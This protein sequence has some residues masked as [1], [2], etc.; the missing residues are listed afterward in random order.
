MSC[1]ILFAALILLFTAGCLGGGEDQT[2]STTTS[3]EPAKTPPTLP[4][5]TIQQ[6]AY[7]S[8]NN[9]SWAKNKMWDDGATEYAVYNS[10]RIVDGQPVNYQT[11]TLTEAAYFDG[12]Y[13]VKNFNNTPGSTPIL[14][15]TTI[16]DYN[17]V[18]YPTSIMAEFLVQRDNVFLPLKA[19]VSAQQ[20]PGMLYKEFQNWNQPTL[21]Y[22]SPEP[23]QGEGK[24]DVIL[25]R[26]DLFE[27]QLPIALRS[28]PMEKGFSQYVRIL[29]PM[30]ST[31]VRT[32]SAHTA[33]ITYSG[34]DVVTTGIGV[35]PAQIINVTYDDGQDTYWLKK[36]YPNTLLKLQN[37]YG[38]KML[39]EDTSRWD[40]RNTHKPKPPA[41]YY[42]PPF[43][44]IDCSEPIKK[45]FEPY[46]QRPHPELLTV[47]CGVDVLR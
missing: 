36:Q 9:L 6:T 28:L 15:Y 10:S 4:Q 11:I 45:E 39:L 23:G 44:A 12:I 8:I 42:C 35:I 40:Y 31:S 47:N 46:C 43:K 17:A 19:T 22:R 34:E 1:R 29:D 3:Y 30:A 14:A 20:W 25:N 24:E 33:R 2:T 16:E 18:N 26:G 7:N 13:H 37:R 21:L 32:P 27:D 41:G 5:P 38:H